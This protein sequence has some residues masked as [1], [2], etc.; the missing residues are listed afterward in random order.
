M[1]YVNQICLDRGKCWKRGVWKPYL[2]K[3]G[4]YKYCAVLLGWYFKDQGFFPSESRWLLGEK[5][6]RTGF[7]SLSRLKKRLRLA[8]NKERTEI[9]LAQ[10]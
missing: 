1:N 4:E 2:G 10:Y 7:P 3:D 9:E 8:T 6:N 5:P